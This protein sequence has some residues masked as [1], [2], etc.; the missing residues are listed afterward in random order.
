MTAAALAACVTAT[1]AVAVAPAHAAPPAYDDYTCA[2]S[3]TRFFQLRNGNDADGYSELWVAGVTGPA[4]TSPDVINWKKAATFSTLR[5]RAIAARETL[6]IEGGAVTYVYLANVDGNLYEGRWGPHLNA[7]AWAHTQLTTSKVHGYSRLA[8]DDHRLWGVKNGDL[9]RA[10]VPENMK[11]PESLTLIQDNWGSPGSFFGVSGSEYAVG[12]T[13]TGGA[14]RYM[15]P[16]GSFVTLRSSGYDTNLVAGLGGGLTYRFFAADTSLQRQT[17]G[18]I[19]GTSTQISGLDMVN[20]WITTPNTSPVTAVS[21][22]CSLSSAY[23]WPLPNGLAANGGVYGPDWHEPRNSN[24]GWHT[25][26]DFPAPIGT[27]VYAAHSGT[28]A[29]SPSN[30]WWGG[31]NLI[32][33]TQGGDELTTWYAHMDTRTVSPGQD[34]VAGQQVGTVGSEGQSTGPHLHFEVHW[35][36]TN[37]VAESNIDPN[38][39]LASVL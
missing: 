23:A 17:I 4:S 6:T 10:Y 3:L 13:G 37:N 30:N 5:P 22:Q 11:A 16:G 27:P 15:K 28:V 7:G 14:L 33:V 21:A 25:G 8:Y 12:F 9:Y 2:Q 19:N 26:E 20:Q 36:N 35:N 18:A 1:L 29:D 34:V 39:W 38:A 24:I 31:P 32:K